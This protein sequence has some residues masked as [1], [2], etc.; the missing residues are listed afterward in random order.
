VP[1]ARFP[2]IAPLVGGALGAVFFLAVYGPAMVRP[3]NLGWTMRH[4]TQTY[5]LAFH[6][7][8]REPWRWPPGAIAGV[9]HPVGTSIGNTDAIPLLAFPLKLVEAWLPET[10]Q[11][12]GLWVFACYILQ[13]VFGALLVRQVTAD[14]TLQ[15]LGAL[16]FVQTPALLHRF[17]HTALCA[18]W[19]LLAA[20]W[21][22][23]DRAHDWR[24]RLGAWVMACGAVAAIQ[25][26][27]AVMVVA[28]A[29]ADVAGDAWGNLRDG[30]HGRTLAGVAAVVAVTVAVFWASGYFL[31]G[32]SG[33]L[34]REGVGYF[35]MNLLSPVIATGYS[36]LLP[37]IPA[38]TPGQYE[39]LVYFGAGWLAL[40]AAALAVGGRRGFVL[41]PLRL[42]WVVVVLFLLLAISPVV[43]AGGVVLFD[44]SAS[45]PALLAV[46]R[47]S[48]RFAWLAM[49]VI[50]AATLATLTSRLP[51]RAA[52]AVVAAGVGLQTLD[53]SG[54]YGRVLARAHDP[55][56]AT[57]TDP[58]Q[59]PAWE[60][61]LPHYRHLVMAPPDMC[62]AVWAPPAGD[63]LPFS[64]LAGRH[65]VTVNSGN[66]GRYDVAGVLSYCAALRADLEAGRVH[67]DSFYVL[68]PAMRQVLGAST[69]TPLA[70][71]MANGFAVCATERSVR[72]WRE[73]AAAAGVLMTPVPAAQP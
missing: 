41:P 27:L 58:L 51:R 18:H 33:D 46:F 63:H 7:F 70:C 13:G 57:W 3:T 9:G 71:G 6:H 24:W 40:T 53:L 42:G 39:G 69:S 62:A 22:A 68:N 28:L 47:S 5:V 30:R 56:W 23:G 25:P 35:S 11:Y 36:S 45:A 66:A 2:L 64:L 60:A 12:L 16:L 10:L 37:E 55:A 50:F 61:A 54:A 38:A 73:A 1:T 29:L 34:G 52:V 48:G 59:S 8:R 14:F 15:V 43:T 26:Y 49:Y 72:R 4:D 19:T 67:N 21:I 65:G 31:L 32:T 44:A 20:I 17:G